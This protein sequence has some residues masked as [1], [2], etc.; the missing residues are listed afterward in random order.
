MNEL[1]LNLRLVYQNWDDYYDDV[2]RIRREIDFSDV[3]LTGINAMQRFQRQFAP[4]GTTGPGPHG[5]IPR[6]I[7]PARVIRG[8]D[9]SASASS[10]STYPPA[11][12][13][14]EGTGTFATPKR[15]PY[16]I[17]RTTDSGQIVGFTHPGIHGTNWFERGANR[18]APIALQAFTDKVER[19]LRLKGRI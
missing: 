11:I 8:A 14:A 12:F 1:G 5:R 17:S 15:T 7:K 19:M 2:R 6:S 10:I 18:G 16:F 9:G 3:V 13:T 4:I